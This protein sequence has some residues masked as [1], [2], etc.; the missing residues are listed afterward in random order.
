MG[1]EESA[2]G[3]GEAGVVWG[4]GGKTWTRFHL[5][6]HC[7]AVSTSEHQTVHRPLPGVLP[8]AVDA[9]EG[10]PSEQTA[11]QSCST[12]IRRSRYLNPLM[13]VSNVFHTHYEF[14]LQGWPN[15]NYKD[16]V[17][18][19][20]GHRTKAAQSLFNSAA[21]GMMCRCTGRMTR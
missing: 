11:L 12:R 20:G 14:Q 9:H 4:V 18:S 21:N 6:Q 19:V 16:L 13:G 5:R 1:L 3:D 2:E 8:V 10:S 7:H 17:E 15:K